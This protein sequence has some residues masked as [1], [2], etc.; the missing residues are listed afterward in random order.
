MWST[1][2]LWEAVWDQRT[3]QVAV[4]KMLPHL[5]CHNNV[6]TM[7]T[8]L[9]V[10]LPT[11]MQNST[12]LE[13]LSLHTR[14]EPVSTKHCQLN[15]FFPLRLF[16]SQY[17]S[18]LLTNGHFLPLRFKSGCFFIVF[19]FAHLHLQICTRFLWIYYFKATSY[20]STIFC[21]VS[22]TNFTW[23]SKCPIF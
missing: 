20:L 16:C 21:L 2:T 23:D 1:Y 17:L 6:V 12:F 18:F 13:I 22:I 14:Y 8:C 15:S 11:R 5:A 19:S 10:T 4:Q 7:V 9:L 3:L